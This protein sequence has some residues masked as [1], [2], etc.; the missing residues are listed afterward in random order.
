MAVVVVLTGCCSNLG[1]PVPAS[2]RWLVFGNETEGLRHM[3]AA[4]RARYGGSFYGIPMMSPHVRSLNLATA[5][6]IVLYA[7]LAKLNFGAPVATE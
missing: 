7:Q 6:A 5:A 2:T 4:L 3:P 1:C